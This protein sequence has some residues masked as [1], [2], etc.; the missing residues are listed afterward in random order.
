MRRKLLLGTF[1]LFLLIGCS[2]E[3]EIVPA[4]TNET[5]ITA[6]V[7]PDKDSKNADAGDTEDIEEKLNFGYFWEWPEKMMEKFEYCVY[8]AEKTVVK[9][10][11][12]IV[13]YLYYTTAS[14]NHISIEEHDNPEPLLKIGTVFESYPVK[15]EMTG[16]KKGNWFNLPGDE[17]EL[18]EIRI[19]S[20]SQNYN[21]EVDPD[22]I[23]ASKK[24]SRLDVGT[25]SDRLFYRKTGYYSEEMNG[26]A[27][28]I[29]YEP[30]FCSAGG[31]PL[32]VLKNEYLNDEVG[33]HLYK[34][35]Y[36]AIPQNFEATE[37][38][39][40]YDIPEDLIPEKVEQNGYFNDKEWI[41]N[42]SY[43]W[44]KYS[45]TKYEY[46]NVGMLIRL[47][48]MRMISLFMQQNTPTKTTGFL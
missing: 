22:L 19:D 31:F 29:L 26:V 21:T 8:G 35:S 10:G 33:G 47:K 40:Y 38:K 37:T 20:N 48:G 11:K 23:L 28:E 46:D 44:E 7:T 30:A 36:K 14:D 15:I 6:V 42:L 4:N 41:G 1:F 5:T 34:I 13:T 18:T 43:T 9:D 45:T 32:A 17:A 25:G 3:K 2:S 27:T 24:F 39:Y 16:I 12:E